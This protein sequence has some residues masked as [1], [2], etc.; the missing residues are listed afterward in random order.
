M[1]R[2]TR[3]VVI[4]N[5]PTC[6]LGLF[7]GAFADAGLGIEVRRGFADDEIP[8]DTGGFAALVVLGGE[9]GAN[10]DATCPWLARVKGLIRAAARTET[11]FLGIC[12]GHQLA[13]AALGGTV[14]RNPSGRAIGLTPIALTDAGRTDPLLGGVPAGSCAIQWNS[15]VVTAVPPGAEVLALCPDGTPQAVRFGRRAWGVQFHP[16]ASS[17]I[18]DSWLSDTDEGADSDGAAAAQAIAA[19]DAELRRAWPPFATAFA[20]IAR[21]GGKVPASPVGDVRVT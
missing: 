17:E 15:D 12:L 6:P 11:P 2:A 21:A 13:A 20:A 5:D 18:F 10:D 3:L 9:M 8:A 1:D 14:G 16:E 7:E 19:A 4:Q